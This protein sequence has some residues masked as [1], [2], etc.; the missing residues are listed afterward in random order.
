MFW[1]WKAG[2][3]FVLETNRLWIFYSKCFYIHLLCPLL[4]CVG[5]GALLANWVG[6]R[7]KR[8]LTNHSYLGLLYLNLSYNSYQWHHFGQHYPYCIIFNTNSCLKSISMSYA[9][10]VSAI[11]I[12]VA[13]VWF[14][15]TRSAYPWFGNIQARVNRAHVHEMYCY[16]DWWIT[17]SPKVASSVALRI[18]SF[19]DCF[20]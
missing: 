8:G 12:V 5:W 4:G 1:D 3:M 19:K 10:G 17:Y 16:Y 14:C 11:F 9:L 20:S 6:S 15:N 2:Q 7:C 13:V 18:K